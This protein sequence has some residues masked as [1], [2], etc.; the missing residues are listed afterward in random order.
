MFIDVAKIHVKAGDGGN[1][2]VSFRHE[3]FVD[4]GGP[5]GGDGGDGGDVVFE[6]SNNANTLADFRYKK[7]VKAEDGYSGGKRRKHGR[8]GDD[9]IVKVP[10]GTVIVDNNEN[11]VADLTVHGQRA[12]VAQG[13]KGGYGNAHFVS[14]TRQAPKLA[15]KG[16]QGEEFEARLE[17]KTIAE[18][19]LVGLP[20]AGK[21]TLLG[22]L[23][24]A[25]PHIADY[26]FTTLTPNLGVVDIDGSDG[27]VIADIPGLIEGASKGRGLGDEFLRHIERTLVLLH[28][29]DIY[30]NDI[31]KDYKT[32]IKELRAYKVDLS[33]RPQ[34]VVLN[35]IDGLDQDIV[36]DKIAELKKILPKSTSIVAISAKAK[37]STE[38]MLRQLAAIVTKERLRKDKLEK[39]Q[40]KD[41]PVITLAPREDQWSI[42][43][44]NGKFIVRGRK[45]ERFANRTDF[46]NY[47]AIRRLKDI[48][49]KTGIIRELKRRGAEL[50]DSIR[51]GDHDLEL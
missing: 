41:V 39:K 36:D 46:D 34:L 38:P 8:S 19:G 31:V 47:H 25:K 30:S 23:S 5:D 2:V 18:V 4:R 17:L 20:N 22:S 12:V 13:G 6:A 33:K 14:S 42:E 35:K 43:E 9:L 29:I 27:L 44:I 32:I 24:N 10:V 37:I 50:G 7:D 16:E 26:P 15:E 51:I 1:G 11:V 28:L 21:S 45:I 49:K 48:M 3:K 40:H